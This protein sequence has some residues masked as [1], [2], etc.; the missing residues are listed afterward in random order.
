[1]I[2]SIYEANIKKKA[3]PLWLINNLEEKQKKM[4]QHDNEEQ[5]K[6]EKES[7]KWE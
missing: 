7:A 2:K 6:E 1:M 5:K 3:K 4:S